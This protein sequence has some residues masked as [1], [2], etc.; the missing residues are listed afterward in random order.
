MQGDGRSFKHVAALS[1]DET[2]KIPWLVLF[3]LA[4]LI[5][6]ICQSIS[7]VAYAFGPRIIY[8]VEFITETTLTPFHVVSKIREC[9]ARAQQVLNI[10]H[11]LV[12]SLLNSAGLHSLGSMGQQMLQEDCPDASY[13]HPGRF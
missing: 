1:T 9:D 8:E 4:E 7:R 11:D 3:K 10:Q 2:S 6:R 5:P 12:C 13:P